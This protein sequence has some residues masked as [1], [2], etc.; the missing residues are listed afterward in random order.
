MF[1]NSTCL[2][3]P[4]TAPAACLAGAPGAKYQPASVQASPAAATGTAR[5]NRQHQ[6]PSTTQA[7]PNTGHGPT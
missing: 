7:T 4:A 1:Q 5:R 6:T 3:G 2:A